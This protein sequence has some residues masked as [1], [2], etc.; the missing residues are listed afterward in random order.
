[1]CTGATAWRSVRGPGALSQMF[2]VSLACARAGAAIEGR[3]GPSREA[4]EVRRALLTVGV[5]PLLRLL[6]PVEQQVRVVRQLLDAA[7]AVLGGVEARLQQTQG[8][9]RQREHLAAPPDGL[10]LQLLECHDRVD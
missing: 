3:S 8:E 9:G 7:E 5:A 6:G 1:S 4:R 10:L 2:R